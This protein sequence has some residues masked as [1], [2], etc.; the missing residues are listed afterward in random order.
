MPKGP[1]IEDPF[2]RQVVI[3]VLMGLLFAASLGAVVL[4]TGAGLG[5]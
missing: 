4:I 3:A 5:F 1:L 2:K